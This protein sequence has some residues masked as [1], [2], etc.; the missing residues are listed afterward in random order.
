MVAARLV[1]R[2]EDADIGR[3]MHQAIASPLG[4]ID[5]GDGAVRRVSRVNAEMRCAVELL[6]APDIAEC[7]TIGERVTSFD[8]DADHSHSFLSPSMRSMP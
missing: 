3:K 6:V 5:I 2:R 8:L 4:D 1:F 7:A